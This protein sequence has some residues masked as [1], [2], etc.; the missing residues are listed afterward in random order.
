MATILR[1]SVSSSPPR[2]LHGGGD[3]VLPQPV[4]Q[5]HLVESPDAA[6]DKS[7]QTELLFL[8]L[9]SIRLFLLGGVDL[10]QSGM[11]STIQHSLNDVC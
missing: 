11:E 3:G 4:V 9:S 8:V 10:E 5:L 7:T 1:I 6:W 2:V